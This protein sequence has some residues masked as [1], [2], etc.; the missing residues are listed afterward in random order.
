MNQCRKNEILGNFATIQVPYRG[1]N[2]S[3]YK[4]WK[5]NFGGKWQKLNFWNKNNSF[6]HNQMLGIDPIW[7]NV[8]FPRKI[9]L[10][11]WKSVDAIL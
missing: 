8:N 2:T 5:W 4:G 10:P 3:Q 1:S 11:E 6:T 9:R 7:Y